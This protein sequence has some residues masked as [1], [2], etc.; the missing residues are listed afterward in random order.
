MRS[1]NDTSTLRD[2]RGGSVRGFMVSCH[3]PVLEVLP[4]R[5]FLPKKRLSSKVT[6]LEI[7]FP[8]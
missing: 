3:Y 8:D 5:M 6:E 2:L 4:R 7:E 1:I